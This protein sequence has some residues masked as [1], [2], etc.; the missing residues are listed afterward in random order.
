[1]NVVFGFGLIAFL[2]LNTHD[3]LDPVNTSTY[4]YG[5]GNVTQIATL[6][7]PTILRCLAGGYPKPS[8]TWWKGTV[9]LPM[10]TDQYQFGADYSMTLTRVGLSDLGE[11]TC[12]AYSISGKPSVSTVVLRAYGP[13][14]TTD[15]SEQPFLRYLLPPPEL[16]AP[17]RP[18]PRYPYRPVRPPPVVNNISKLG[19]KTNK[20]FYN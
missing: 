1:M 8:V 2:I 6:N 10:F 20:F 4:I 18:D 7:Q 19:W 14:H 9:M 13:V 5:A 16:P 17:S 3:F 11:Y 15:P 12:Q